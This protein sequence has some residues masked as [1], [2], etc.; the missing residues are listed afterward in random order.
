MGDIDMISHKADGQVNDQVKGQVN[1]QVSGQSSNDRMLDPKDVGMTFGYKELYSGDEDKKGRFTWQTEVPKDLGKPAEDAESEKWAIIVR[2]VKVYND[3]KKVLALHSIAIQS[4]YIKDILK[5]VLSG[6][7]GVTASLK[8]LEFSGRCE[9]LLHRWPALRETI[10]DLEKQR[11]EGDEEAGNRARHA[12][13]LDDLLSEEFS[14]VEE[15]M[16]DMKKN[17]VIT[18]QHMWT[19]YAPNTLIFSRQDNQDRALRLQTSHYGVDRTLQ[20]VFWLT[21][22]YIDF[23]GQNFGTQ[24]MNISIPNFEGTKRISSLD[25]FPIDLHEENEQIKMKL[26]ERGARVEALAGSY[27]RSYNGVGWRIG[28][29]GNKEKHT[30]KGRVIIDPFGYNRFEPDYAVY[31]APLSIPDV[32]P[33]P[34]HGS[35]VGTRSGRQRLRLGSH[36]PPDVVGS[37]GTM[38]S[39][40]DPCYNLDDA[41]NDD[42][43]MPADGFFDDEDNMPKRPALTNEQKLICTPLVRGYALKEKQWLNFFVNSI[44]DISFN[45]LAFSSLNLP[46][47]Q[48]DLILGFTSVKAPYRNQFDDV[49]EGKGKGIIMLL[50]GP[51]GV[52]KTLTAESV[53]EQMKVPLYIMAAGD[54]G[55]DARSVETKLEDVMAMCSRWG[56]ILLLDEADIFL[57]ERSLH[58]LE[59]N[60]LVSIF[61]RV[62]EYYEGIMFLTTNRVRTFDAAFQ[63]RIHISLEYPELDKP[64]RKAIWRNFLQRHDMAQAA[65]RD[66]PA[67]PL[68]GFAKSRS[69]KKRI[70]SPLMRDSGGQSQGRVDEEDDIQKPVDEELHGRL[71]QPH[72]ISPDEITKLS[73]LKINGRQ[74]KNFLKTAQLLAIYK[75]EPLSYNHLETVVTSTQHLHKVTEAT[76]HARGAIYH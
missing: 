67:A 54:L 64:A 50:S 33:L 62:L 21:G 42:G 25:A 53:A 59:R 20:P 19:L 40:V 9:P 27:F 76:D 14:E 41:N 38:P 16:T 65:A 2:R 1:C 34:V 47:N 31:V 57:E 73:E 15:A 66:K 7:P 49:I 35:G 4:P 46:K 11:D 37:M 29:Y 48:K 13:L 23:D 39:Y 52:G 55:L 43:G 24:K 56:A 72:K 51:P 8:R 61:L 75:E 30:V 10:V 32:S 68:D 63:S 74:I 69:S 44:S 28:V 6:Y 71:T 58:E 17:G 5:A 26:V 12:K 18:F 3:P 70:G 22:V 36:L 60:K 45:E